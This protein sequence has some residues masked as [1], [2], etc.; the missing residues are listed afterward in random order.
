MIYI[1]H[2]GNLNGKVVERENSPQYIKEAIEA[3]Y[4]VE[5]DL[6]WENSSLWL[7]HDEPQ[8]KTSVYDLKDM[9]TRLMCHAKNHK[10]ITAL[11]DADLHWFWHDNDDYTI[12]SQG[13]IWAYPGK[14]SVGEN[15]I[16]VLPEIHETDTQLFYGIC[17]DYIERYK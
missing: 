6:W 10:A 9:S 2:R 13:F 11:N 7:G 4:F 5:V 12:T 8:Y 3:G 15:T 1:S 17:S 14:P 16:A